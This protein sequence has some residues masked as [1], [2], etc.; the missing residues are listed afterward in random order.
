MCCVTCVTFQFTSAKILVRLIHNVSFNFSELMLKKFVCA[1]SFGL[2]KPV[3][4][5]SLADVCEC[6]DALSAKL[7]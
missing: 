3:L 2:G 6:G 7:L 4:Q 5:S 1:I